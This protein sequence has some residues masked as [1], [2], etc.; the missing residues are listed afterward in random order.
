MALTRGDLLTLTKPYSEFN[1]ETQLQGTCK[2]TGSVASVSR[3]K[4]YVIAAM[5]E[6]TS[7]MLV[8]LW[9]ERERR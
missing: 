6:P 8:R 7:D 2:R 4:V 5:E 1:G 9:T 3:D